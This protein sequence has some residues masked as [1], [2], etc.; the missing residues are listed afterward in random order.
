MNEEKSL[1]DH[2]KEVELFLDKYKTQPEV[3][4]ENKKQIILS[5]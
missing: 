1:Q 2:L 3:T 4:Y 5:S